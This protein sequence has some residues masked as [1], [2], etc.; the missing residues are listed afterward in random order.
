MC[1]RTINKNG[2][3]KTP[4][5]DFHVDTEV[6]GYRTVFNDGHDLVEGLPERQPEWLG[7]DSKGLVGPR[8]I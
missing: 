3:K 7:L 2:N 6:R 4:R 5:Y 1:G 8:R